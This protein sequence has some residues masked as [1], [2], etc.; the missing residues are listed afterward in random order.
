MFAAGAPTPARGAAATA[1][2]ASPAPREA[3]HTILVP[4]DGSPGGESVLPTVGELALARGPGCDCFVWRR[5]Q[6]ATRGSVTDRARKRAREPGSGDQ[7]SS[8]RARWVRTEASAASRVTRGAASASARATYAASY[9]VT[10]RRSSQILDTNS[11]C[12]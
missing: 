12:G 9:A 1:A 10:F 7:R 3:G 6:S 8:T 11:P 2:V 4:L 5:P